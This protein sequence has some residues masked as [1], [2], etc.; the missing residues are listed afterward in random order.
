MQQTA[1]AASHRVSQGRMG[2]GEVIFWKLVILVL[3]P[4]AVRLSK[5]VVGE[6]LANTGHVALIA[7]EDFA[8][9]FILIT[10]VR[11]VIAQVAA[12]L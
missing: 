1:R 5:G 6:H 12:T 8:F 9:G 11:Q 3:R 2:K 10:T 4:G 7:I